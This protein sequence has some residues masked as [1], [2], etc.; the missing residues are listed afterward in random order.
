MKMIYAIEVEL[1][2]FGVVVI[3]MWGGLTF[4]NLMMRRAE[5]KG[6]L[7]LEAEKAAREAQYRE[8]AEEMAG[9]I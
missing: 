3:V 5:R 2:I 6:Q 8:V 4:L 7:E 9:K 1:L